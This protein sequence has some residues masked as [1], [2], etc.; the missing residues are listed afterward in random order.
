MEITFTFTINHAQKC[1]TI[2]MPQHV[3]PKIYLDFFNMSLYSH[4]I[5]C[6]FNMSIDSHEVLSFFSPQYITPLH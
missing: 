1:I 4:K 3:T 6:F 5:L 2:V